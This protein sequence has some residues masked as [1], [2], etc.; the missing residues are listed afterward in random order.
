MESV[1]DC[2]T[3]RYG[4]LPV[5]AYPCAACCPQN[6]WKWYQEKNMKAKESDHAGVKDDNGKPQL[7]LV[8]SEFVRILYRNHPHRSAVSALLAI[9]ALS[10]PSVCT[11]LNF[12]KGLFEAIDALASI[13]GHR[14]LLEQCAVAMGPNGGCKKYSRNNWRLGMDAQ[15]L[16]DA[17][18]RHLVKLLAGEQIDEETTA[19]HYGNAAFCLQC[20]AEYVREPG[21]PHMQALFNSAKKENWSVKIKE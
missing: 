16:L 11:E 10:S 2:V 14:E 21:M 19:M 18:E 8:C 6:N 13:C 3:C 12:S 15:R 9:K 17:A 5:A 20:I 4:A 7:S 1:K